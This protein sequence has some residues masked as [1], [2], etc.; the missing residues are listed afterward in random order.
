MTLSYHFPTGLSLVKIIAKVMISYTGVQ[1]VYLYWPVHC[2]FTDISP[3]FAQKIR[4]S[5]DN[6]DFLIH[7]GAQ[8]FVNF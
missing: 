8:V 3:F 7:N 1:Y 5:Y 2:P 4:L 6:V